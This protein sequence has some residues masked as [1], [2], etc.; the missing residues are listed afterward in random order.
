MC[1]SALFVLFSALLWTAPESISVNVARRKK[2]G[3]IYSFGIV[4]SD[5]INRLPPFSVYSQYRPRGKCY[6]PLKLFYV[7]CA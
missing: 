5:I 2:E 6:S 4:I 1:V 3:D 7:G